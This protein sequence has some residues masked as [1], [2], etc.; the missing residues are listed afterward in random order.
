MPFEIKRTAELLATGMTR[1]AV[2]QLPRVDELRG[3]RVLGDEPGDRRTVRIHAAWAKAPAGSVLAGWAAAAVHGV[4]ESFVDGTV[5]GVKLRPVDLCVPESAGTYDSRGLRARKSR[6]PGEHVVEIGEFLVTNGPRT[7]LDLARWTGAASRRLA[8]LDLAARFGLIDLAS[9]AS[10]LEPLGGLHGLAGVRELVP[11]VSAGAES[12]PESELRH[13]W[14][15]AGLP[16]PLVN[17]PVHD[18]YGHFV[19]RPDLL[20]PKSGLVGEYQGF[21]HR[22]DLA[23]GEDKARR[24]R[25]EAMNLTVVEIWKDDR[26]RVETLLLDGYERARSRDQRLDSWTFPQQRAV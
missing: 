4:P 19:G 18:R 14:L 5:D 3:V 6:I 25:F 9:F 26:D 7:A 24:A 20:D 2:D 15:A 11:Q 8:M 22:L 23:P 21:W 1:H 16:S 13:Q 10:F 12:I 17:Q